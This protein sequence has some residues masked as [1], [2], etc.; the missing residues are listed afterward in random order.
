MNSSEDITKKKIF[1]PW[2]YVAGSILFALATF[3]YLSL[4]GTV[5]WQI[6]TQSYKLNKLVNN[7]VEI[8]R[9]T[10]SLQTKEIEKIITAMKHS[11]E[12]LEDNSWFLMRRTG[13]YQFTGIMSFLLSMLSFREKPRWIGLISL[14]FGIWGLIM[15]MVIM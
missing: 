7:L 12:T 15:S 10:P 9:E 4:Y 13:I 1:T 11:A 2:T 3:N 6:T 14:P 8:K 5:H